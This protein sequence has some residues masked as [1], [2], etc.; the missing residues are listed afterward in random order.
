MSSIVEMLLYLTYDN[1]L[2]N[3][4]EGKCLSK[5]EKLQLPLT[6][7]FLLY[8]FVSSLNFRPFI[9]LTLTISQDQYYVILAYIG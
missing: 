3:L 4:G 8:D 6:F 1:I 2:C 5:R 9:K 7:F